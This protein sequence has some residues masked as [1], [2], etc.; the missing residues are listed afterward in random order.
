MRCRALIFFLA[1]LMV[2]MGLS[3]QT[4]AAAVT[5]DTLIEQVS[6]LPFDPATATANAPG[7]ASGSLDDHYLDELPFQLLADLVGLVWL[8]ALTGPE[9]LTLRHDA[10]LAQAGPTPH[11]AGLRRPPIGRA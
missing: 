4:Q 11:L 7:R 9:G 6:A 1:F 2:W 5:S 3:A 8:C 10:P